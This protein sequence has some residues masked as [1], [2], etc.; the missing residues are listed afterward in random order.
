MAARAWHIPC[1]VVDTVTWRG[2]AWTHA[3][4]T[5]FVFLYLNIYVN[6]PIVAYKKDFGKHMHHL[7]H[8]DM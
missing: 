5:L 6:D 7:N 2:S 1:A 8:F 4:G 3:V